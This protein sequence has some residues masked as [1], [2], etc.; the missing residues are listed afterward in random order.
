M[1]KLHNYTGIRAEVSHGLAVYKVYIRGVLVTEAM[2]KAGA[3]TQLIQ[4]LRRFNQ[5]AAA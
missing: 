1:I 3:T 5:G 2:S 4:L